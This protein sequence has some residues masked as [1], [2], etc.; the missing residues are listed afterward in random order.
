MH[1]DTLN[2]EKNPVAIMLM[3]STAFSLWIEY[4]NGNIWGAHWEK[5]ELTLSCRE[6]ER[7]NETLFALHNKQAK[8]E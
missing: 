2:A 1:S 8:Q 5:N 3:N 4:T 6:N 7:K